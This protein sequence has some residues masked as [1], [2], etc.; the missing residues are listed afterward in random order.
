MLK[1]KKVNVIRPN[2]GTFTPFIIEM[3]SR[4]GFLV[5]ND[6]PLTQLTAIESQQIF[7]SYIYDIT[8]QPSLAVYSINRAINVNT[9]K[10]TKIISDYE[11]MFTNLLDPS[12]FFVALN[13]TFFEAESWLVKKEQDYENFLEKK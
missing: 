5:I 3:A 11:K 4:L 12:R 13:N 9:P 10:N 7:N 6:I 1:D 8:F 2:Q